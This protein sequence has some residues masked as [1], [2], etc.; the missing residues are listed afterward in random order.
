MV[1]TRRSMQQ[2]T[3][4]VSEGTLPE[5]S[6]SQQNHQHS[7]AP[8]IEQ[9][10][11]IQTSQEVV[12][13]SPAAASPHLK[14][15][16]NSRPKSGDLTSILQA[17]QQSK[18]RNAWT[19]TYTTV[20]MLGAFMLMIWIGHGALLPLLF[21]I[22]TSMFREIKKLSKVLSSK[23]ELPSFRPLHWFWFS[24]AIFFT[25]GRILDHYFH[26]SL[27]YHTFISFS[28]YVVGLLAFVW[29]LKKGYYKYQFEMFAWIHLTLLLIVVQSTFV[30]VNMFQGLIWFIMPA[31]LIISNDCWAYIFGFFFGRTPLIKLSPKKTWEGFIGAAAMTI[32]TGALIT[33]WLSHYDAMICPKSSLDFEPVNCPTP[34]AFIPARYQLP[35]L[36]HALPGLPDHITLAPVQIHTFVFSVFASLI[37]PFGGFFA[38][39]FKRA[40]HVKDFGE[41]IPGHGG[42]TDRMDCQIMMGFFVWVYYWTFIVSETDAM[43]LGKTMKIVDRM[44]VDELQHL[45]HMVQQRIANVSAQ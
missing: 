5:S 35:E 41:S 21:V 38:S 23:R 8:S 20:G 36:F 9:S 26:H 11:N 19:R 34:H 31:L 32:V 7:N 30:V 12:N 22:Q 4:T 14:A 27:P 10:T 16:R 43:R 24:V 40:F 13:S 42:V 3:D 44:G 18:W 6:H 1:V 28:L 37:A 2:A 17:N 33:S 39:G 29:S 15:R 45:M 25:Y